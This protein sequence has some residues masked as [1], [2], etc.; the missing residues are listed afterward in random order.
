MEVFR[1]IV[2]AGFLLA[3]MFMLI[4]AA[5]GVN[6]FSHA[7][8]RIH[9]AALGDTLGLLFAI[10]GLVVWNGLSF[11]SLKLFA[12]VIFFWLASPVAGHMIANLELETDED[13]GDL[14]IRHLE[15]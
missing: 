6:R 1:F 3:G 7:L 13:L 4:S 12:V 9:A 8:N 15:E 14:E 2:A 11:A 10:L 5:F